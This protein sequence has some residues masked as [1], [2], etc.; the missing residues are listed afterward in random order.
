MFLSRNERL[1]DAFWVDLNRVLEIEQNSTLGR[2]GKMWGLG[3]ECCTFL[4]SPGSHDLITSR[5]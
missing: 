2:L 3:Q 4:L 1:G 5:R